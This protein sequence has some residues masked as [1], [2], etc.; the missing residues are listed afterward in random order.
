MLE[1]MRK[2]IYSLIRIPNER[3][4]TGIVIQDWQAAG[5]MMREAAPCGWSDRGI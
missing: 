2:V 4:A 5:P 3:R 1:G